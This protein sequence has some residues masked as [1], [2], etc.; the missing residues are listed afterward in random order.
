M[1]KGGEKPRRALY[2]CN[3]PAELDGNADKMR[4][5]FSVKGRYDVESVS[6]VGT[7]AAFVNYYRLSDAKR[8]VKRFYGR[9]GG[10][11]MSVSYSLAKVRVKVEDDTIILTFSQSTSP[12]AGADE[13]VLVEQEHLKRWL[14][15]FTTSDFEMRAVS[16]TAVELVLDDY[17][18][19]VYFVEHMRRCRF[20]NGVVSATFF[21]RE[22]ATPIEQKRR[23]E[24]RERKRSRSRSPSRSPLIGP[25]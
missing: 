3:V 2:V 11:G 5:E 19:A 4:D 12:N 25:I 15:Q 14:R 10:G 8:V 21:K 9:G 20:I 17:R 18:D 6:F 22:R 24:S 7:R 16:D 13:Q 23:K 1:N